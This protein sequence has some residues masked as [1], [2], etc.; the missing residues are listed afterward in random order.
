MLFLPMF[1]PLPLIDCSLWVILLGVRSIA[2]QRAIIGGHSQ[3]KSHADIYSLCMVSK[4][5]YTIAI[6]FLYRRL[7]I[8]HNGLTHGKLVTPLHALLTSQQQEK[9]LRFSDET[10][11]GLACG[12]RKGP[13]LGKDLGDCGEFVRE[14]EVTPAHAIMEEVSDI[15]KEIVEC[16]IENMPLLESFAYFPLASLP[17]AS[18]YWFFC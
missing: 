1:D 3:L 6:R 8:P 11:D 13:A 5:F 12:G 10:E 7:K 17:S 16:A 4:Y 2:N 18:T 15:R 14:F 9:L